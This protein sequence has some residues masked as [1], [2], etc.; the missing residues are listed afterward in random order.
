MLANSKAFS[1]FAVDDVEQ[2]K[3]FYGATFGLD[4]A[5]STRST[6]C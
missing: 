1:S 6:E 4:V 2:A 3:E 5:V